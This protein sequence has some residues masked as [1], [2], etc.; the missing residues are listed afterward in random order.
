MHSP[1]QCRRRSRLLETLGLL[2]VSGLRGIMH[3]SIRSIGQGPE[4]RDAI[5]PRKNRANGASNLLRSLVRRIS[6]EYIAN[7]V[8]WFR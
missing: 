2:V 6:L 3:G 1:A 4:F 5:P 8:V 7:S